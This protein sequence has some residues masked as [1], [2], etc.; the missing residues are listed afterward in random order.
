MMTV[1]LIFAL[2]IF[3][4]VSSITPGPNNIMLM[5][6]GTNFGFRKTIPHILGINIGYSMLTCSLG[7]GLMEVFNLFPLIKIILKSLCSGYLV[8]LSYRIAT[9]STGTDKNEKQQ[10]RPFSFTEAM[11]FQWVNPKG[12]TMALS[13]ITIYSPTNALSGIIL[14]TVAFS[15]TNFP[16]QCLWTLLGQQFR[17]LMS[18]SFKLKMFNYIMAGLLML[19]L[20]QIFI[21]S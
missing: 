20:I 19:P 5:A 6:S 1:E 3:A 21:V 13:A 10:S 16:C 4:F 11:L 15:I 14:V 7:I 8:Y 12:W 2:F 9:S 17:K 18:S